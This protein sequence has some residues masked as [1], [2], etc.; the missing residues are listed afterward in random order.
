MNPERRR[1]LKVGLFGSAV[2]AAVA[3]GIALSRRP[4]KCEPCLWLHQGD[5]QLLQAVIPVML[6]GALPDNIDQRA[7]SIKAIISGFDKTVAHFPPTVRAEIRQL[8]WLLESPLTRPLLTGIWSG[9]RKANTG[10]IKEFLGSWQHSRLDLL[11][12]GYTALH[13]LIMGAW[14]ANPHSWQ[15]IHYPGP[16]AIA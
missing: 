10:D 11:R 1:F 8:L 14:Y 4:E 15:R 6:A 12:V 5:R 9:W 2:L 3:G 16:P 13:D 7:Q